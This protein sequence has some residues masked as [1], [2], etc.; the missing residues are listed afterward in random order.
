MESAAAA[1]TAD[2]DA[3]QHTALTPPAAFVRFAVCGGG[4]GVA[5]G[6]VLLP[7][8]AWLPFAVAN[9]L[10]TVGSTLLATE[11][12]ARFSFRA[13]RTGWRCHLQSGLTVVVSYLFT[14]AALTALHSADPAAGALL[15]QAVYLAASGL[16]G[17]G[18]FLVLRLLVFSGDGR[19]TEPEPAAPVRRLPGPR[20]DPR[21]A[22]AADRT[23]LDAAA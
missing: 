22:S 16:A 19:R 3:E 9:A 17:I 13:A 21:D 6:G 8:A 12:H 23:G 2:Q 5:A 14:T 7:L 11:L 20:P 15:R 4:V 10:V 1:D 18:R